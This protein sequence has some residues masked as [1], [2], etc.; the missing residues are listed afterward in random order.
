MLP[1]ER[2]D[3]VEIVENGR[4]RQWWLIGAAAVALVA[5]AAALI[6][7]LTG[8]DDEPDSLA[9]TLP[10]VTTTSV[11]PTTTPTTVAVDFTAE[12]ST[13]GEVTRSWTADDDAVVGSLTFTNSADAATAG[14][15]FEVI[16]ASMASSAAAVV[17]TPEH[18]VV[19]EPAAPQG[20]R[21]SQAESPTMWSSRLRVSL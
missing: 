20:F 16:P 1:T 7:V 9:I 14:T 19:I 2:G 4:A 11:P 3:T 21:R 5:V 18:T 13:V 12:T 10:S 15:H 6:V 8:G 17:S